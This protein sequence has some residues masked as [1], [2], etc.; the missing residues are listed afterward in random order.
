MNKQQIADQLVAT[1]KAFVERA[2][3][4]LDTRVKAVEEAVQTLRSNM[5]DFRAM[6]AEAVKDLPAPKDGKDTDPAV[7]EALVK[8]HFEALPKP[9][10]GKSVTLEEVQPVLKDL[11]DSAV[12]ALPAAAPGKDA[13]P[14]VIAEQVR[15]AVA[16]IPAPQDGKSVTVEDVQ[17]LIAEQIKAAVEALPPAQN[18]TSVTV[19]DVAPLIV[20]EVGKA[21]A[22]LPAPKDGEPGKDADPEVIKTLVAEAVAAMPAPAPGKDADPE[23]MRAMV[24]EM[25]AA[26]PK[27]ADGKSIT[28]EDVAPMLAELVQR[29]VD[30]IPKPQDGKSVPIED[31][32][33]MVEEQVAKRIAEIPPA[34]DGEPGRDAAHMDVLP[35]IDVERQYRRGTFAT[36]DGGLWR[37]AGVTDGM[38]NWECIVDGLKALEIKQIDERTFAVVA[39]TATGKTE[40]KQFTMPVVIDKG[41]FREGADYAKGDGVT[42]AGSFYIAQKDKPAGKPGESDDFRLAVKRGRDG[43]D[44]GVPKASPGG[45]VRLGT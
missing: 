5:P 27:P 35:G 32:A 36:H 44:G 25:L 7:I 8:Q 24:E 42:W 2:T 13:D 45:P 3:G 41:V 6:L 22:A 9:L 38:R 28:P 21:V 30:A 31:V 43:K 11:V 20:E 16:A 29:A 17:P 26:W 18:G 10:D 4:A 40:R 14:A 37:S 15:T 23:V 39:T 34:K 1:V 19:E 12:A 33:R